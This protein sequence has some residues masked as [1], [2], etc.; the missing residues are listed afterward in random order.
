M[1]GRFRRAM[2]GIT[3]SSQ[4]ANRFMDEAGE[5]LDWL[6]S[7][8]L[9]QL[10]THGVEITIESVAGIALPKT[11]LRIRIGGTDAEDDTDVAG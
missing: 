7:D 4:K 9:D 6:E 8:V 11:Q 1:D 5:F 10:I 2:D 3:N